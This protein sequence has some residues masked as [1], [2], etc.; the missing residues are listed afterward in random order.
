MLP[1][2]LLIVAA[3]AVLAVAV[4]LL[5]Q[6]RFEYGVLSRHNDV[7]GFLLSVV[8]V[9]YA[10]VLGFVVIVAWQKYDTAKH[11]VES[12]V[13]ATIDLDHAVTGFPAPLRNRLRKQLLAYA[14]RVVSDEW[15][16]MRAGRLGLAGSPILE[17]VSTE[18]ETFA[19]HTMAQADTHQVALADI[20]RAWDAR[21]ERIL[22][23]EP[24]VPPILWMALV[25]GAVATL[26]FAYL[27]G[28]ENRLAQLVMTAIVAALIGI[29]FVVIAAFDRPFRG[30][31]GIAPSGW[32]YFFQHAAQIDPQSASGPH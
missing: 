22:Q 26:G 18:I 30:S 9:I 1:I 12:E 32:Y 6:R 31:V 14:H 29:M 4:H 20:Q 5:V 23:D 8:G 28:V 19:P 7:A 27:F 16:A 13:A 17:E 10:V 25:A 21:R 2:E 24:S 11:D 15:P 3:V